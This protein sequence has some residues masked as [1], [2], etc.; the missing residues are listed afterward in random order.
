MLNFKLESPN[1]KSNLHL[2]F[3][4]Q[5]Q[6]RSYLQTRLELERELEL[7]LGALRDQVRRPRPW[8]LGRGG[9]QAG[10][11]QGVPG[12]LQASGVRAIVLAHRGLPRCAILIGFTRQAG[13]MCVGGGGVLVPC[14]TVVVW[15][16]TLASPQYRDGA[17]RVFTDHWQAL[18]A[19]KREAP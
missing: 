19:P 16:S 4:L 7:E 17:R 12:P 10:R 6:L 1:S 13:R 2:Q 5:V 18:L 8:R 15:P 11:L 14:M 3:Q 9:V